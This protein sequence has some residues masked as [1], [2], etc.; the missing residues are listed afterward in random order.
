MIG[1]KVQQLPAF[2][3]VFELMRAGKISLPGVLRLEAQLRG[4]TRSFGSDKRRARP[5]IS[6]VLRR[7]KFFF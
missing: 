2:A 1:K 7:A 6:D 5:F 3:L 4:T